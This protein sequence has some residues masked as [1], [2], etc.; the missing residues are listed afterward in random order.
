MLRMALSLNKMKL[1][2]LHV[3]FMKIDYHRADSNRRHTR[4]QK[5]KLLISCLYRFMCKLDA[6]NAIR[7]LL[8]TLSTFITHVRMFDMLNVLN[9]LQLIQ[10]SNHT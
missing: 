7:N 2:V 9:M 5:L 8:H 3:D 1:L 6:T 10:V 4:Q